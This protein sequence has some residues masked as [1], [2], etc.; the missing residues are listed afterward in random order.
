MDAAEFFTAKLTHETDAADV[1]ADQKN[2]T[3]N[4]TLIDTR[5]KQHY[6]KAHLPGAIH[7]HH[8]EMTPERI[9]ELPEGLLVTYCWGPGCNAST[10]GAL[11]LTL[12]GREAKE[13]LGGFEYWVR[14]G[15]PVE[16]KA[17][18]KLAFARD[19]ALVG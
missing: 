6:D 5:A 18:G 19:E 17:R 7:M 14:E 4:Y 3:Q 11:N 16:G 10:R 8:S 13:M 15:H 2:G 12:A 9:A 1:A